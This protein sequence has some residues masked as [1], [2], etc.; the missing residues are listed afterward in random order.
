MFIFMVQGKQNVYQKVNL[1]N[2][3]VPN[4][5]IV[6]VVNKINKCLL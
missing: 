6:Q 1:T 3:T 4:F 5:I 2:M